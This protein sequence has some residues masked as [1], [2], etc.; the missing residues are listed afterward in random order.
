MDVFAKPE[1]PLDPAL[2]I[3]WRLRLVERINYELNLQPLSPTL[4]EGS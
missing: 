2:G 3:L 4:A 1:N